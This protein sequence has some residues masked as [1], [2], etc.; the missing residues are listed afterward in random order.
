M[1]TKIKIAPVTEDVV[2]PPQ[3]D[4]VQIPTSPTCTQCQGPLSPENLAKEQVMC[5]PCWDDD[6]PKVICVDFNVDGKRCAW[7]LQPLPDGRFPERCLKHQSLQALGEASD[8]LA[9]LRE[10]NFEV[11]PDLTAK[12]EEAEGHFDN[13]NFGKAVGACRYFQ[14]IRRYLKLER[15]IGYAYRRS[16]LGPIEGIPEAIRK[17]YEDALEEAHPHGNFRAGYEA[18]NRFI[19]LAKLTHQ[20]AEMGN[21]RSER[22]AYTRSINGAFGDPSNPRPTDSERAQRDA[23]RRDRQIQRSRNPNKGP[24]NK[25]G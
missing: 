13:G 16:G 8:H 1:A 11:H 19:E 4:E 25:K 7:V 24:S 3:V 2:A 5:A 9:W 23:A 10:Q 20:H 6:H 22:I 18:L 14:N 15:E 12:I 17:A 21:R